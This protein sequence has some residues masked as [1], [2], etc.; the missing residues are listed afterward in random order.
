[1]QELNTYLELLDAFITAQMEGNIDEINRITKLLYENA[2]KRAALISSVN[3]FWTV[4][5]WRNRL[6]NNL[7]M[8]IDESTTFL[9]GDY[10][11]NIDIY[12]RIL[13]LAENTSS[14]FA[15]GLFQYI[16]NMQQKP[17][18]QESIS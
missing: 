9:M 15:Q 16:N 8:T 5:E 13:D 2:D 12:S 17:E 1:L 11:I 18:P 3:P 6:Y 4:E 7:R 14:Y 10:A